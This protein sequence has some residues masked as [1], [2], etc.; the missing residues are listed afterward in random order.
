MTQITEL[1]LPL[2]NTNF[3]KSSSVVQVR[4][5]YG[6][7]KYNKIKDHWTWNKQVLMTQ[8]HILTVVL[9]CKIS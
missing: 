2:M 8:L 5:I 7:I 4:K 1:L 3:F 9:L 6:P